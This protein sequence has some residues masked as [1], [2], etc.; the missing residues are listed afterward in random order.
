M[1]AERKTVCQMAD[2]AVGGVSR[3]VLTCDHAGVVQEVVTFNWVLG[4]GD[5]FERD[6]IYG[7]AIWLIKSAAEVRAERERGSAPAAT[8]RHTGRRDHAPSSRPRSQRRRRG[9]A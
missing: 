7:V 6:A 5:A 3:A 1:D 4:H 2:N 9:S 8:P